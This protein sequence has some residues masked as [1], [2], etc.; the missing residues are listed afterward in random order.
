ML[1]ALGGAGVADDFLA[2]AASWANSSEVLILL[3]ADLALRPDGLLLLDADLALRPDGLLLLDADLA[4]RPDGLLL[5]E[6][7]LDLRLAALLLLETDLAFSLG[8]G[9][10]LALVRATTTARLDGA[11]RRLLLDLGALGI[12]FSEVTPRSIRM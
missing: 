8:L 6:A 2:T 10:G 11:G 9:P 1:C 3:D 5:L 4:L 12:A 7:G